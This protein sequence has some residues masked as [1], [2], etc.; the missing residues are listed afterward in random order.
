[1]EGCDGKERLGG[2]VEGN[3][4]GN[5]CLV[6]ELKKGGRNENV[7]ENT[8]G[9]VN[10]NVNGN[11]NG[12]VNGNVNGNGITKKQSGYRISKAEQRRLDKTVTRFA[13]QGWTATYAAVAWSFGMVSGLG[14]RGFS[15]PS[16]CWKAGGA[17]CK[18]EC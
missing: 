17:G 5:G 11:T 16:S 3:G 9:E 13:E 15:L 10:G 8:N 14:G 2:R 12:N 7:D 18:S 4:N 6:G 1:M